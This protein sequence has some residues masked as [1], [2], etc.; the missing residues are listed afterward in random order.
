MPRIRF[1]R[2][3]RVPRH[4]HTTLRHSRRF[5]LD[6]LGLPIPRT[7][8]I[9]CLRCFHSV[10]PPTTR[11]GTSPPLPARTHLIEQSSY[12]FRSTSFPCSARC[13][14]SKDDHRSSP[15]LTFLADTIQASVLFVNAAAT[16][17]QRVWRPDR[18]GLFFVCRA[19]GKILPVKDGSVFEIGK[20]SAAFVDDAPLFGRVPCASTGSFRPSNPAFHPSPTKTKMRP[21]PQPRFS[22]RHDDRE[23]TLIMVYAPH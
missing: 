10:A 21:C 9:R 6:G 22:G 12:R 7:S 14:S 20:E 1:S 17:L 4:R 23:Q 16:I 5:P 15:C 3:S 11:A 13:P 8:Y 18:L 19:H 2:R